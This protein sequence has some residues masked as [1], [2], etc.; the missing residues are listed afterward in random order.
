MQRRTFMSLS[1]GA[2]TLPWS[3]AL[4]QGG[5]RPAPQRVLDELARIANTM[6]SSRYDHDTRVDERAGRYDFD[7]SAMAAY[8]LR[9]SAPQALAS[10]R[11]GRPVAAGFARTIT[12]APVGRFARGWQHVPRLADARPGDLFAWERPR[13]F[14]S[15]NTGHVGFVVEA[16]RPHDLG[17]L[18]RIIDSTRYAHQDDTRDTEH[19]QSGFGSG[20]ILFATNPLTGEGVGYGWFGAQTHPDWIIPT[21]VVIGRVRG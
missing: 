9:R 10:L 16:P 3:E 11:S 15:N 21:R 18:V 1:L 7:C 14:P 6:R 12:N 5:S 2:L 19:G 17:V 13:W 8:V 20:T 4:A